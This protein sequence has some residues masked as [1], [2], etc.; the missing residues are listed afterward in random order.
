LRRLA[1]GTVHLGVG[2]GR[3]DRYRH[4]VGDLILNC[5]DID[6]ITIVRNLA[7]IT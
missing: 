5:K 6:E 2:D 4:C 3:R 1:H 7:K